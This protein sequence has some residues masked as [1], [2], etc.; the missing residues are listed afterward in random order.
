MVICGNYKLVMGGEARGLRILR[1]K[2]KSL[3][4]PSVTART[5][6]DGCASAHIKVPESC[7]G[8]EEL[9]SFGSL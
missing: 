2:Y 1:N 5:S 4:L 7:V 3:T 8:D 9:I 6:P